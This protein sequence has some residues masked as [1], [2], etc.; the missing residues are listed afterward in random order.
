M[1][2][3]LNSKFHTFTTAEIVSFLLQTVALFAVSGFMLRQVF[4]RPLSAFSKR[5]NLALGLLL[6]GVASLAIGWR[7]HIGIEIGW[8][9]FVP[10][11]IGA[12]VLGYFGA[13]SRIRA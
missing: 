2:S 9:A 7:M 8:S 10:C 3:L 1:F 11:L 4:H 13:K 12:F 5:T 6:L